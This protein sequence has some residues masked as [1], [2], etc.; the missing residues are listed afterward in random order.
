MVQFILFVARVYGI[1]PFLAHKGKLY[2]YRWDPECPYSIP[3]PNRF[4]ADLLDWNDI[5][6]ALSPQLLDLP[7]ITRKPI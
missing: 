1:D 3:A 7:N 5:S 6:L 4:D 2:L